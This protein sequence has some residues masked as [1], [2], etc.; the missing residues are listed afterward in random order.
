M[1]R[2]KIGL[3]LTPLDDDKRQAFELFYKEQYPMAMGYLRQLLYDNDDVH[4]VLVHALELALARFDDYLNNGKPRYWFFGILHNSATY[5]LRK[6]ARESRIFMPQTTEESVDRKT[7]EKILLHRESEN[8]VRQT[9]AA[10][11]VKYREVVLLRLENFSYREIAQVL[12]ISV[13]AAESRMR[14]AIHKLEPLYAAYK[15]GR[16]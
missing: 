14:R 1:P 6:R 2:Q 3:S 15:E 7:P 5:F 4:D 8:W 9:I 13:E 12:G 11:P 16:L 10:L